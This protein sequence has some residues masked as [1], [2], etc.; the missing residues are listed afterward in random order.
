MP[1]LDVGRYTPSIL[2]KENGRH[3]RLE[4]NDGS[5][6]NE[7]ISA[8][9]SSQNLEEHTDLVPDIKPVGKTARS[10]LADTVSVVV[11]TQK[12]ADN[13]YSDNDGI[14]NV[15]FQNGVPS[16]AQASGTNE[17]GQLLFDEI[18]KNK[19]QKQPGRKFLAT[20]NKRMRYRKFKYKQ[21]SSTAKKEIKHLDLS[22]I[23]SKET[24]ENKVEDVEEIFIIPELP[25]GSRMNINILST[26][27]DK[28]Y[29]GLNGIE[30]FDSDGNIVQAR[31]VRNFIL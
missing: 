22:K 14:L 28:F 1:V 25:A 6:F 19:L 13:K 12:F 18:Y 11:K 24:S 2:D 4:L 31:K 9:N 20:P 5:V 23:L 29:V 26:W 8:T 17:R 27:G 10:T 21:G 7:A 3:S 30:I 16:K 15:S